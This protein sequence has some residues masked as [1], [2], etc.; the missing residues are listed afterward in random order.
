M[1]MGFPTIVARARAAELAG[2]SGVALMDH[3]APPGL[4]TAALYDPIATAAAVLASTTS[5]TVGHLVLAAPYHHPAVLAKQVVTLDHLSGGR[6]ELGLG[7][8]STPWQ[9]GSYGFGDRSAAE[10]AAQLDELLDVVLQLLS[11]RPVDHD[12]PCYRL[13]RAIQRPT[14]VHGR[15]PVTVAGSGELTLPIAQR[16]ADWWSIPTRAADQV[17]ALVPRA[18]RLRVSLQ[19]PLGLAR[20]ESEVDEVR[21]LALRRFGHWGG[22][23]VG[24]APQVAEELAALARAG[25]ERFYLQFHDFGRAET[26]RAFSREVAPAVAAAA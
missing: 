26:L 5:L 17:R 4:T 9:V 11:G 15:V 18:G 3:M 21:D 19:M 12:G 22:L 14:P 8:G 13:S 20:D 23:V 10:R 1:R 7:W 25:V 16:H 2:F 6:Y 24:T